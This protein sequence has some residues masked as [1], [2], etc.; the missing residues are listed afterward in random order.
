[1]GLVAKRHQAFNPYSF[2]TIAR[3]HK[4]TL[5]LGF[6]EEGPLSMVCSQTQVEP[7]IWRIGPNR[8]CFLEARFTFDP[9]CL[10]ISN[11]KWG[12]YPCFYLEDREKIIF[13]S[14]FY[15][16]AKFL[17]H[18]AFVDEQ[19]VAKYLAQGVLSGGQTFFSQ[20]RMLPLGYRAI[21]KRSEVRLEKKTPQSYNLQNMTTHEKVN[22]LVNCFQNS[23]NDW[24]ESY[25]VQHVNLSGGAD[26]RLILAALG[27]E[28]R[29]RMTFITDASPHLNFEEDQ[30]VVI[31]KKLAEKF[32]LRHEVRLH[33][34]L[35][36]KSH[37]T[38][39]DLPEKV[40][41]GGNH[42]GEILGLEMTQALDFYYES[43]LS[44]L[45]NS[46]SDLFIKLGGPLA[47]NQERSFENSV[48][49]LFHSFFTDIYEGGFLN[50]WSTPH[51][52]IQ[53]KLSPFWNSKMI[54]YV[55]ALEAEFPHS[56]ELYAHIYTNYFPDFKEIPFHS[57]LTH[58]REGFKALELGV[59]QKTTFKN[60]LNQ[61]SQVEIEKLNARIGV[62][63]PQGFQEILEREE[64]SILLQRCLK[65]NRWMDDLG[66]SAKKKNWAQKLWAKLL[67]YV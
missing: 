27:P 51:Q 54:D 34:E 49:I 46:L 43:A 3:E 45:E 63:S 15:A 6:T 59:D 58:S 4:P 10:T 42:G 61:R 53:R 38:R 55:L 30:D 24:V 25:G 47:L 35:D 64:N 44:E 17:G 36:K 50:D 5:G 33:Q 1:M 16:L 12:T 13:S 65:F 20:I 29:E 14:D 60:K 26:T 48:D 18:S 21:L 37:F 2:Q 41:L 8:E 39:Q 22:G 52:F 7:G 19:A 28:A 57:V 66:V 62:F 32:N 9:F 31:A 67:S 56:Y 23:V 11:D 40:M